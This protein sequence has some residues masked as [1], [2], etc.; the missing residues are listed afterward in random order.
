M[1][2]LLCF[3]LV[4]LSLGCSK[5]IFRPYVGGQQSWPTA[6]GSIVNV[7]YDLPIFTTLPPVPYN[8]VG[9]LRI[10]SAFFEQPEEGHLPLLVEKAK[11]LGA[12]ALVFVQGKIYFSTN[13]GP[14]EDPNAVEGER[15]PTLTQVNTFDPESFQ[16]EVNI[17]AVQWTAGPPPGLEW[18]Y[19]PPPAPEAM[20]VIEEEPVPVPVTEGTAPEM[21]PAE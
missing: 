3:A 2:K 4:L 6:E 18:A 7:K 12:D 19:A 21:A 1:K 9:E 5:A 14:R 10:E 20:P 15:R 13:Y 16:R 17:L 8:V 11:D